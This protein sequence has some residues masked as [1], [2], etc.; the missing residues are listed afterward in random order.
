MRRI[1]KSYGVSDKSS[2]L[3]GLRDV[4]R[5]LPRLYTPFDNFNSMF[6]T[7]MNI[8]Q[9]GPM[10]EADRTKRLKAVRKL[11]FKDAQYLVSV[12]EDLIKEHAIFRNYAEKLKDRPQD[13]LVV[14]HFIDYHARAARTSDIWTLKVELPK[15][16][17]DVHVSPIWDVAALSP[18]EFKKR[19]RNCGLYSDCTAR[20]L[21]NINERDQFD[22][23]GTVY[24]MKKMAETPELKKKRL[25]KHPETDE[26]ASYPS[27]LFPTTLQYNPDDPSYGIFK[28]EFFRK[29]RGTPD[30]YHSTHGAHGTPWCVRTLLTGATSA[31]QPPGVP[32]SG[33][34]TL[35]R[36]HNIYCVTS[37][38]I[39]YVAAL[40]Q[41]LL[42]AKKEWDGDDADGS[43]QLL[44]SALREFLGLEFEAH[45]AAAEDGFFQPGSD[46]EE[47]NE[48]V[49]AYFNR[50][51]FGRAYGDDNVRLKQLQ[52]K[53]SS[54]Y[55]DDNAGNDNSAKR[56]ARTIREQALVAHKARLQQKAMRRLEQQN[57]TSTPQ[58][59]QGLSY[60]GDDQ[61]EVAPAR[62]EDVMGQGLAALEQ[63]GGT[64]D[65]QP[66]LDTDL[67][68]YCSAGPSLSDSLERLY[69]FRLMPLVPGATT[70]SSYF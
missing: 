15:F 40:V 47:M 9:L 30:H 48:N 32:G 38:M 21:V 67:E 4:A 46:V 27:F 22:R 49:F 43:G 66:W 13:I 6:I 56:G 60:D 44:H 65:K 63:D 61:Q 29:V 23:N 31:N 19:E 18:I 8:W 59:S 62:T 68:T 45:E 25:R 28:G 34:S 7:G 55:D 50:W 39:A 37:P 1:Q 64:Q 41:F 53:N 20:L 57:D 26:N 14:A 51:I 10:S 70:A 3:A 11:K 52:Q 33:C 24:R 35:S 42:S 16:F 58:S 69:G 2:H 12:F 17:E 5:F 54:L 36:K